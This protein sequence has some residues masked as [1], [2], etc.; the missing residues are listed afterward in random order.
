[1]TLFDIGAHTAGL[2]AYVSIGILLVVV[3]R[4]SQLLGR[5]T[6]AKPYYLANYLA[7]ILIWAGAGARFY[8]I[9]RGQA[10]LDASESKLVYI[11]LCDGLPALGTLIGLLATWYYWSWLL[12]ER[13]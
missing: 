7:A 6:R 10:Y 1:M 3:A 2:F 12:A 11:L 13:D 8:F 4:L 9:T 5:V